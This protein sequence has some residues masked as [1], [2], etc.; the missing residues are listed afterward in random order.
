MNESTNVAEFIEIRQHIESLASQIVLSAQ[1]KEMPRSK[2]KLDEANE[3]L[4]KLTSMANND[5]QEIAVGRLT[6]QLAGLGVKVDALAAKKR[7][8]KKAA[9][10]AKSAEAT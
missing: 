4:A 7:V 6:R 9:A 2:N 1:Q 5:V 3:L 8:V 10:P